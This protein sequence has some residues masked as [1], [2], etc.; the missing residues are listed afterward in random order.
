MSLH[1][2][3][4]VVLF[5][6]LAVS[7]SH[8]QSVSKP[9][10]NNVAGA[11]T[12]DQLRSIITNPTGTGALVYGTQ[13]TLAFKKNTETYTTA[14]ISANTLTID[15]NEGSVFITTSNANINTFTISNATAGRAASFV[16]ILVGNGGTY[17]QTWGASV[18]W[19]SGAAPLMSTINGAV[20]AITFITYNGGVTWLAFGGGQNFL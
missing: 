14:A 3:I 16:L 20:D 19:P 11:T 5:T 18:K 8:A 9:P 1:K 17:N 15:L 7:S 6:L 10:L 13:P 2:L 4:T 12:S